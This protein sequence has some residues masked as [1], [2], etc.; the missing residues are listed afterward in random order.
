MC[1]G[2]VDRNGD[3]ESSHDQHYGTI[4]DLIDYLYRL[5]AIHP[6]A[7][8]VLLT[9]IREPSA[10]IR[11][12]AARLSMSKT[13]VDRTIDAIKRYDAKLKRLMT[14]NVMRSIGQQTRRKRER[15]VYAPE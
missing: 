12:V 14:G 11:E 8:S 6:A 3:C 7:P 5:A 2:T 10:T 15:G 13:N 1:G 4:S 9:R